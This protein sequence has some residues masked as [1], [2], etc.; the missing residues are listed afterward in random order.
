MNNVS[1]KRVFDGDLIVDNMIRD[2]S[3]SLIGTKFVPNKTVIIF[4]ELQECVN[5]RSLLNLLC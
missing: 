1:I 3:G 2:L 4:D 5:A